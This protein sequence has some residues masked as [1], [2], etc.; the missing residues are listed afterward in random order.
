MV[1]QVLDASAVLAVLNGEAGQDVVMSAFL[2]GEAMISSVN[3]GEV[4]AKLV[5]WGADPRLA[6]NSV[7]GLPMRIVDVD[8]GLGLRSGEL[9]ETTRAVGLSLGDRVCLALAEREAGV[10]LTADTVWSSLRMDV[11][12]RQIR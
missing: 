1:A 3:A 5:E 2:S 11:Q 7:L 10:A 4:V 6:R 9:R 12:V 8:A